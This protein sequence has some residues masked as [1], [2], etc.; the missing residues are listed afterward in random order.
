MMSFTLLTASS[1]HGVLQSIFQG[2]D[3]HNFLSLLEEMHCYFSDNNGKIKKLANFKF[4]FWIVLVNVF[5]S[6]LFVYDLYVLYKATT[7]V[8]PISAAYEVFRCILT[9]NICVVSLLVCSYASIIKEDIKIINDRLSSSAKVSVSIKVIAQENDYADELYNRVVGLRKWYGHLN[10]TFV[11]YNEAFGWRILFLCAN[12]FM[13]F[14]QITNMLTVYLINYDHF[15][16][17]WL[18]L[19]IS[20]TIVPLVSIKP[21]KLGKL[22]LLISPEVIVKVLTF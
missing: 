4:Y 19:I 21:K 16:T 13:E 17:D 3:Y 11:A 2:N 20:K 5:L 18:L 15:E 22:Y 1:I 14:L 7:P 12:A 6:F 9:Y 10:K 8:N